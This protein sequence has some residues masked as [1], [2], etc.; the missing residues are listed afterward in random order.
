MK[1]NLY[2]GLLAAGLSTA[3]AGCGSLNI[4]KLETFLGSSSGGPLSVETIVAG[5]KE[6]LT[7]GTRNTVTQTSKSG[8]YLNNA[9][10]RIPLPRELQT[11]GKTMRAV[12]LSS[13]VEDFEKKMN[14]AAEQAATQAAPVFVGAIRQ[15]TFA[16]AK[17]ILAGKETA[18]TDYFR[19]KTSGRL[20]DL[21]KPI[22]ATYT[23]QSGAA[24]AYKSLLDRYAQIP[25]VPKPQTPS[26]DDF[27]TEK[28]I[29]GLFTILADEEIRI[30]K[31]PAARTTQL[32][33]T[34]FGRY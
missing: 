5:L 14:V 15:M 2:A 31:D 26:L 22:I 10:I 1:K 18:A 32:L 33:R 13:L 17:A 11:A 24:R 8:G 20:R 29:D 4:T 30:R 3:L 34:V 9:R 23:D 28:A 16:D 27:V 19:E 7:V 12:G 21:Y 6:A 25:L